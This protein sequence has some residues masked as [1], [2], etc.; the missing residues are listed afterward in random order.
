MSPVP[1][2]TLQQLGLALGLLERNGGG[3]ELNNDWLARPGDFLGSVLRDPTQREAAISL[4]SSVLGEL[5]GELADALSPSEDGSWISLVETDASPSAGLFAVLEMPEGDTGPLRVSLAFK[6]ATPSETGNAGASAVARIPLVALDARPHGTSG[7]VPPPRLLPGTSDGP[8]SLIVCFDIPAAG[9]G[10]MSLREAAVTAMVPTVEGATPSFSIS[11]KGLRAPGSTREHDLVFDAAEA[12]LGE[13]AQILLSLVAEDADSVLNDV[14][15]LLGLTPGGPMPPLHPQDLFARGTAAISERFTAVLSD[16]AASRS[17]AVTAARLL[18]LD[19]GDVS[20]AGTMA[21]PFVLRL[22]S[23]GAGH[24]DLTL[25][26][27]RDASAGSIAFTPGISALWPTDDGYVGGDV[28]LFTLTLGT[29]TRFAPLTGLRAFAR[30]GGGGAPLV[31]TEVS[32]RPLQIGHFD[33][34]IALDVSGRPAIVLAAGDVSLAGIEYPALDLGSADVVA[35]LAEGAGAAITDVLTDALGEGAAGAALA[36]AAGLARP[37]GLTASEWTD[38]VPLG[39]LVTDPAGAIA[40]YQARVFDDEEMA[41]RAVAVFATVLGAAVDEVDGAGTSLDPWRARLGSAPGAASVSELLVWQDETPRRLHIGLQVAADLEL[42]PVPVRFSGGAELISLTLPAG[43]AGTAP[44]LEWGGRQDLALRTREPLALGSAERGVRVGALDLLVER[45]AATGLTASL[46]VRDPV[47]RRPGDDLGL[48]DLIVHPDGSVEPD[49]LPASTWE[50]LAAVAGDRLAALGSP[51]LGHLAALLGWGQSAGAISLPGAGAT[52]TLGS[53]DLPRLD[54]GTLLSHP[55]RAVREWASEVLVSASATLHAAARIEAISRGEPFDPAQIVLPEGVASTSVLA[56]LALG[57]SGD[58]SLGLSSA[59]S[60]GL[61][62][63]GDVRD[64]L[65]ERAEGSVDAA[66]AALA[67]AASLAPQL[68]RL[69]R[70]RDLDALVDALRQLAGSDGLVAAEAQAPAGWERHTIGTGHLAAPGAVDVSDLIAGVPPNRCIFVSCDLPSVSPWRGQTPERVVDL[71]TRGIDAA[72]LD[73]SSA[74][75]A[76]PW[77][78][79]IPRLAEDSSGAEV[80]LE[81]QA[82]RIERAV[83]ALVARLPD[84]DASVALIAHS[85]AGFAAVAAASGPAADRLSHLITVATP[86]GGAALERLEAGSMQDA[87]AFARALTQ[88][89]AGDGAARALIEIVAAATRAGDA[90]TGRA[91]A[92]ASS[93]ELTPPVSLPDPPQPDRIA[94]VASIAADEIDRGVIDVMRAAI[95]RELGGEDA[96]SALDAIG[97]DLAFPLDLPEI[98]S[99]RVAGELRLAVAGVAA[100]SG[101]EVPSVAVRVHLEAHGTDGWLVPRDLSGGPGVRYAELDLVCDAGPGSSTLR[102]HDADLYGMHRPQLEIRLGEPGGAAQF[103]AFARSVVGAIAG[104]AAT[105]PEDGRGRALVEVASLL[106]LVTIGSAGVAASP[107]GVERF[108]AAPGSV[109]REAF[110]RELG[111]VLTRLFPAPRAGGGIRI[112]GSAEIDVLLDPVSRKVSVATRPGGVAVGELGRAEIDVALDERGIEGHIVLAP[113]VPAPAGPTRVRFELAPGQAL[114]VTLERFGDAI[115]LAPDP[116]EASLKRAGM[117]L[118]AGALAS[119]VFDELRD[120]AG[121]RVEPLLAAAGLLSEAANPRRLWR[122]PA[123]FVAHIGLWLSQLATAGDDGAAGRAREL[124]AALG[125]MLD[126]DGQDGRIE[127]PWDLTLEAAER[128]GLTLITLARDADAGGGGVQAGGAL[129]F[130]VGSDGPPAPELRATLR[131]SDAGEG[132]D[133]IWIEATLDDAASASM[134]LEPPTGGD[135]V[136]PLLPAASVMGVAEQGAT[137]VLPL[138]LDAIATHEELGSAVAALGDALRLRSS[139]RFDANRLRAAGED[140]GSHLA[141]LLASPPAAGDLFDALAR[142]LRVVVGPGRVSVQDGASRLRFEVADPVVL[143]LGSG[144]VLTC[145]LEAV[146]RSGLRFSASA[147]ATGGASPAVTGFRADV[148]VEDPDVARIVGVPVFPFVGVQTSGGSSAVEVGLWSSLDPGREAMIARIGGDAPGVMLRDDEGTDSDDRAAVGAALARLWLI[149][150]AADLVLALG[151]VEQLLQREI[152]ALGASLQDLL[153]DSGVLV[154]RSPEIGLD[155]G[156]VE[157]PLSRLLS[158]AAS[159]VESLEPITIVDGLGIAAQSEERDGSR[160]VGIRFAVDQRV[161]VSLPGDLVISLETE[162]GWLDGEEGGVDLLLLSVPPGAGAAVQL[163]PW[164]RVQGLG[165][166]IGAAGGDKLFDLG[167]SVRSVAIHGH[168]E[169]IAGADG[170]MVAEGSGVHVAVNELALPLARAAGG[171]NPVANKVLGQS[172]ETGTELAP[173]FSPELIVRSDPGSV[174][175]RLGAGDPPWWVPVQRSFGPLYVEQVGINV[176]STGEGANRRL[177]FVTVLMDGGISIA[178]LS[179]GVDDLA[180]T[181][182][183]DSPFALQEWS[184]DLAGL[185]LAYDSSGVKIAGGLRKITRPGGVEYAGMLEVRFAQFGLTAVGS[186]GEFA[187]P[188]PPPGGPQTYS[189]FFVFAALDYPIGGPPAFFVTG[190]GAGI[191][192]NRRLVLPQDVTQVTSH[193]LVRAMNPSSGF[194]SDP[195][196]GLEGMANDFPPEPGTFWLALG[197]RFTSF[198]LVES[199]A[200]LSAEAGGQGLEIGLLGLSR[201]DLPSRDFVMARI[202][203]ALRA[204]FSTREALIGVQGQLTDNS[205]L[206][207]SNCRL[208]GGFAFYVWFDE[209]DFVL[210]LGGYHPRFDKPARYPDVP[211][212]GYNWTV[213]N[214]ITIKGESYFAVTA[215]C[216]MAGGSFEASYDGGIAW[217]AFRMGWN[218]LISWDPFFYDFEVYVSVSAGVKIRVCA[219]FGLGCATISISLSLGASV[220]VWG[221]ELRGRA[222]LDLD[223]TSV[224][225][226]FGASDD[227]NSKSPLTWPAFHEKYLIAGDPDGST[228]AATITRGY[229]P[230]NTEAGETPGVGSANDPW[231]V[232]PEFAFVTQTR[233][234]SNRL[235]VAGAVVD[236]NDEAIDL[237]PMQ[238]AD[239][240]SHHRVSVSGGDGAVSDL[241]FTPARGKVPEATWGIV[242]TEDAPAARVRPAYVGSSVDVPAK[243]DMT[244]PAVAKL[245]DVERSE[246]AHPLPFHQ[247]FTW[248]ADLEEHAAAAAAYVRRQPTAAAEILDKAAVKLTALQDPLARAAYAMDVAAPPRIAPLSEGLSPAILAPVP[249]EPVPDPPPP[250]ERDTKAR[251]PRVESVLRLSPATSASGQPRTTVSAAAD[252]ARVAPPTLAQIQ[253]GGGPVSA[254]LSRRTRPARLFERTV[255]AIGAPVATGR[256]GGMREARRSLFS[257]PATAASLRELASQLE[258]GIHVLGGDMVVLTV[259]EASFD[260]DPVRPVISVAGDQQVRVAILD[261]AGDPLSDSTGSTFE[262]V[263]PR[264][265]YRILLAGLGPASAGRGSGSAGWHTGAPLVQMTSDVYVGS[266]VIVRATSPETKRS[267]RSVTSAVVTGADAVVDAD[268][269]ETMLPPQTTS[270]IV[271]LENVGEIDETLDELALSL[272]GAERVATESGPE[273]PRIVASGNRVYAVFALARDAGMAAVVATVATGPKWELIGVGGSSAPAEETARVLAERGIDGA[274]PSLIAYAGGSSSVTWRHE[275]A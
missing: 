191:G 83:T 221:P 121:E 30:A 62:A 72:A 253:V 173:T 129:S 250:A 40:R 142:S 110:S 235:E 89:L 75:A 249:T 166:R 265:A 224:T 53:G 144:G 138:V 81:D 196:A 77:F 157:A 275:E 238:K 194:A 10:S 46:A 204:R 43:A 199:I 205:W 133:A 213:S 70:G 189:S 153:L 85:V 20:G 252:V 214:A 145:E 211:R 107:T 34:G 28:E 231:R 171:E 226:A 261:R 268:L 39:E 134:R 146:V 174:E 185:A 76:G 243:I 31:Q 160:F 19:G 37:A 35:Q 201:M 203:L 78:V 13:A 51:A 176:T 68:E 177:A 267:R 123:A 273:A 158:L 208:T 168:Y 24:V 114:G 92:G 217:A 149:P 113:L 229:I 84:D 140:P 55:A 33:V 182:P 12:D 147:E 48:P 119:S 9:E 178:G 274:I 115:R 186:Y 245:E 8:I 237:G 3:I 195:M 105:L 170:S 108:L 64:G 41:K 135:I 79:S 264:G 218:A 103:D 262:T 259:P 98:G 141:T 45:T 232:L 60:L 181:I 17:M 269:V 254:R 1:L 59:S 180:L 44:G 99:L 219:P 255:T 120:Q 71:T 148:V 23:S 266:D 67:A 74:P 230:V 80:T 100:I 66:I 49:D 128:D 223:V 102:L 106:G 187:Q 36:T 127:L 88:D 263:V 26:M 175:L 57:A 2:E 131:F 241:P 5:G 233:S 117:S 61:D 112:A 163:R 190:L 251:R 136:L 167:V 220:H 38:L 184:V 169:A 247:E 122:D 82:A 165:A 104:T 179:M 101:D 152:Q 244:E 73:L 16:P 270:L 248:R 116:D 137:A 56:G 197:V 161:Q 222:T 256:A 29:D 192:L 206:I 132:F 22:A 32:G 260:A 162:T 130:A 91:G 58:A 150:L 183:A 272:S 236:L 151:P 42:G 6:F 139:G 258:G 159:A 164:V 212:L 109:V 126:P 202:E 188:S 172:R 143:T 96:L 193:T 50:A 207:H 47:I 7:S 93:G 69:T 154:A 111:D 257:D 156:F 227:P 18:G 198:V 21:D 225:V 87:L 234:A 14:L 97:I 216:V 94:V 95:E 86:H 200:V 63:L 27:V 15:A 242:H 125:A 124:I 155:P 271:G 4:A 90:A 118:V 246:S 228:M 215:S 11:L 25:V 239:V 210:T 54:V 65:L 240:V 52:V 209:G